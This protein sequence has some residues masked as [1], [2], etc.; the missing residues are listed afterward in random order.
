[1]PLWQLVPTSTLVIPQR[2]APRQT[3]TPSQFELDCVESTARHS[4][5]SGHE[6][7]GHEASRGMKLHAPSEP[8][9]LQLAHTSPQPVLQHTPSTQKPDA[10]SAAA[11]QAAPSS[12]PLAGASTPP[13]SRLFAADSSPPPPVPIGPEAS[14]SAC[15]RSRSS[16]AQPC[17]IPEENA[18]AAPT[19]RAW[20]ARRLGF[21]PSHTHFVSM[22]ASAALPASRT[23]WSAAPPL[24]VPGGVACPRPSPRRGGRSRARRVDVSKVTP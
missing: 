11:L 2:A 3:P 22:W 12:K 18:S 21:G 7:S 20:H 24:V 9:A 23:Q 6:T 13:G 17:T 8:G 14:C 10:Q 1:M 4:L 5:A 19:T 16:M 15:A